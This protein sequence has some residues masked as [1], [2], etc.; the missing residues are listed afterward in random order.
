M[1]FFIGRRIMRK[2]QSAFSFGDAKKRIRRIYPEAKDFR[3]LKRMGYP[4][5]IG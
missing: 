5:N 1:R 4:H 3:L 2:Q